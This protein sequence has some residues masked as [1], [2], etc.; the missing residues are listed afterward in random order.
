[1]N[2]EKRIKEMEEIMEEYS[3]F[4]EAIENSQDWT[5]IDCKKIQM[6]SGKQI[7]FKFKDNKDKT[8]YI[9]MTLEK[10]QKKESCL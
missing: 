9:N 3:I 1:M 2:A 7:E 4:A 8:T 10:F 6:A 5:L